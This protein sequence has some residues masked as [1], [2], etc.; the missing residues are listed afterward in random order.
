[1]TAYAPPKLL[2]QSLA[3]MRAT[4]RR[5]QARHRGMRV[6]TGTLAIAVLLALAMLPGAQTR[7]QAATSTG[8]VT[9]AIF[10]ATPGVSTGLLPGTVELLTQRGR[11]VVSQRVRA[12]HS[13][14][15][16]AAP[17]RYRLTSTDPCSIT[18]PVVIH[19]GQTTHQNVAITDCP[20]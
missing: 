4:A 6:R 13:F 12:G 15:L 9:G 5:L 3:S 8:T 14:R 17:G 18:T 16:I 10:D 11:L 1:M 20:P 19:A 2:R 7:V